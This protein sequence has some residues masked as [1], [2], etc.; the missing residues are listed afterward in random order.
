MTDFKELVGTQFS[1]WQKMVPKP[2]F[3]C[4][5][6]ED[7]NEYYLTQEMNQNRIRVVVEKGIITEVQGVH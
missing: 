2:Y 5:I 4:A 3:V 7:G 1:T 6:M